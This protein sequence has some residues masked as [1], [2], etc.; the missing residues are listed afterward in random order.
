MNG[1]PFLLSFRDSRITEGNS[2]ALMVVLNFVL[3]G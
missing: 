3:K 2:F 1:I